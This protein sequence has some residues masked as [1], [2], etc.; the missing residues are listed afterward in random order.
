MP[1]ILPRIQLWSNES[2]SSGWRKNLEALQILFTANIATSK[3][4][5]KKLQQSH[6]WTHQKKPS[7]SKRCFF[8][9]GDNQKPVFLQLTPCLPVK[10]RS[11]LSPTPSTNRAHSFWIN[12]LPANLPV[13]YFTL[14]ARVCQ[15]YPSPLI[16]NMLTIF[17]YERTI[18]DFRLTGNGGRPRRRLQKTCF[19]K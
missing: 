11:H 16:Q 1:R 18:G 6:T 12:W 5:Q 17:K 4:N 15:W 3:D 19:Q 14:K 10:L 13:A 2:Q 7:E 9:A 8:T